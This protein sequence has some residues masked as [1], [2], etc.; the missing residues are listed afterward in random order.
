MHTPK[1]K[2]QFEDIYTLHYH[3]VRYFVYN[4]LHDY[5][6]ATD[7]AQEVFVTLWESCNKVDMEK[8]IVPYLMTLAKNKCMNIFKRREVQRRYDRLSNLGELD[9][10][11]GA[12]LNELTA[13]KLYS[14]EV[15]R[16]YSKSLTE[17][18]AKTKETFLLN[19]EKGLKYREIAAEQNISIKLVEYR[20]MSALRI[21]RKNL[22]DYLPSFLWFLLVSFSTL[23]WV[24][25]NR[26]IKG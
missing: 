23:Y 8:D 12:T 18:S 17:M 3:K 14:N 5:E 15:E 22:K 10:L 9:S 21:V 7:I 20:I 13:S 16:L 11:N 19:K 1:Q 25:I 26:G 24:I 6:A 2:Q 4:Y